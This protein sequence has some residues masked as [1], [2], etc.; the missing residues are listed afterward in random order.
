M[1]YVSRAG[2]KLKF[3]LDSFGIPIDDLV[4]ADFGSSTGGFVDCLL[5]AG[6]KK[7]YSV[8]VSYGELAWGLRND[9]RVVVMERS[10][11]IHIKLP[12]K[13]GFISIDT[14]WT[15]QRFVIPNAL[16]NLKPD[17]MIVSLIKPHYEVVKAKLSSQEADQIVKQ[18]CQEIEG[19]GCKVEKVIQS[20]ILGRKGENKEY[21]ALVRPLLL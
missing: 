8:D 15:K 4:C 3:A 18:V 20:P 6:V 9:P 2:E 21:L 11:A 7:V 14:G 5:Q 10:N 1:N 13:V 12:E 16:A 17:G 19:L